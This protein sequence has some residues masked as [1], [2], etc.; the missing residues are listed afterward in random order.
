MD[1]HWRDMV[2]AN[3]VVERE[4]RKIA[5][6]RRRFQRSPP[7]VQ[8]EEFVL[9]ARSALK[10]S[11][12]RRAKTSPTINSGKKSGVK[13]HEEGKAA[14]YCSKSAGPKSTVRTARKQ[15]SA[16]RT[17]PQSSM[18]YSVSSR[19]R[20]TTGRR[21]RTGRKKRLP[22][23]PLMPP[24]VRIRRT[25]SVD[26]HIPSTLVDLDFVNEKGNSPSLEEDALGDEAQSNRVEELIMSMTSIPA[27]EADGDD[28]DVDV[29]DD[30]DDDDEDCGF[31]D[32]GAT[33]KMTAANISDME[34][35]IARLRRQRRAVAR[36]KHSAAQKDE[37]IAE[38]ARKNSELEEMLSKERKRR[39]M[40]AV[41]RLL[42]AK[43]CK[44][45]MQTLKWQA[46]SFRHARCT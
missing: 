18:I 41:R 6:S 17:T 44:R 21:R 16:N 12:G 35:S 15:S 43:S 30:D 3:A 19:P 31:D 2:A 45:Q 29:D 34:A 40:L 26:L 37:T 32:D 1:A 14:A 10:S 28:H 22:T 25:G 33:N 8:R 5:A 13:E 4:N 7:S 42:C 9:A 27:Y 11:A 36:L 46:K 20:A 39:A 23:P 38:L 24:S